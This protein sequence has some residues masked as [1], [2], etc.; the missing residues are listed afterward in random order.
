MNSKSFFQSDPKVKKAIINKIQSQD[1]YSQHIVN[2]VQ[3]DHPLNIVASGLLDSGVTKEFVYKSKEVEPD[4]SFAYFE[5]Q[6][7]DE[8]A[9]LWF[10][11]TTKTYF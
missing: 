7:V 8:N 9:G 4:V 10:D 1:T 5:Q 11:L 3:L 2:S 6:T